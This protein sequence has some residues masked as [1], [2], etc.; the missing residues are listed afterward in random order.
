MESSVTVDDCCS[1]D[2]ACHLVRVQLQGELSV[3]RL[4][5]LI[6]AVAA[7]ARYRRGMHAIADLRECFGDWDYSEIQRFR[8]FV[9]RVGGSLRRRWA[10]IASPGAL[11]AVA[12]LVIL[13]SDAVGASI[14][15]RLFDDPQ[16]AQG[17]IA[18][19]RA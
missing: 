10:V 7:D 15:M 14:E 3:E 11:E 18:Q 19:D 8:D 9:V 13:I 1:F 6:N 4:T 17:W 2:P 16:Q 12:H 5:T